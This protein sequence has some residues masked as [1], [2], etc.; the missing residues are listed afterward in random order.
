M[1]VLFVTDDL[2]EADLIKSELEKYI[3][4]FRLDISPGIPTAASKLAGPDLVDIVLL[5]TSVSHPDKITIAASIRKANRSTG[6]VALMRESDPTPHQDLIKAGI[7]A[8][9]LKRAGFVA[10]LPE[11]F[12]QAKR[13]H[14]GGNGARMRPLTLLYAGDFE[15]ARRFL[16]GVPQL[17]L[18]EATFGTDGLLQL[19]E[20]GKP[21]PDL[22]VFDVSTTGTN[23]LKAI[24][25]AR[26]RAS[27]IP[28]ILLADPG[29]DELGVHAMRAGA[30]D[31]ITKTGNYFIRLLLSIQKELGRRELIREKTALKSREERLRHIV[32]SMPVGVAVVSPDGTVMAV[33]DA[34]LK[35][36]QRTRL[37]QIVGKALTDFFPDEERTRISAFLADVCGGTESAF[38]LASA[39]SEAG[40]PALD[41]R[42]VPLHRDNKGTIAALVVLD[43][44]PKE[45]ET[46]GL[47]REYEEK[48]AALQTAF[49]KQEAKLKEAES[50]RTAAEA[51]QTQ[52]KNAVEEIT[53]RYEAALEEH[54]KWEEAQRQLEEQRATSEELAESLRAEQASWSL[55]AEEL[56]Q[57]CRAAEEEAA[58]LKTALQNA[59][60]S[61]SQAVDALNAELAGHQLIQKELEE[62]CRIAED[63]LRSLNEEIAR[64]DAIQNELEQKS[65]AAEEEAAAL[66]TAL[67]NAQY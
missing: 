45:P 55:R 4:S 67:Q 65:K 22:I 59:Q 58:A 10:S 62:K 53:S 33:N 30:S 5:D 48:I 38:R 57:K 39:A 12:Q 6:V 25:D 32:E 24:K 7:D 1:N 43:V 44:A 63:Q 40:T 31:C 29:N 28:I 35:L 42:G 23:T 14:N 8:V 47:L 66:K 27:E 15:Q 60:Y 61:S 21:A 9:V 2:R 19:Q 64:R 26:M 49:E 37:D 16:S 36:I 50:L 51:Q 46:P 17:R 52:L 20:P 3:P 13:H 34:G 54:G 41:F 18:E 56:Q 11:A